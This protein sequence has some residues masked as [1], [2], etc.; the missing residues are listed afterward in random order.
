VF[1]ST[2]TRH[3]SKEL[4]LVS[5]QT[6]LRAVCRIEKTVTNVMQNQVAIYLKTIHLQ[7]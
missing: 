5:V 4:Q 1:F 7:E 3:I 2:V 6:L